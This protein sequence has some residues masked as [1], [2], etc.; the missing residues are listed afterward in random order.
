MMLLLK[1]TNEQL[2]SIWLILFNWAIWNKSLSI[3]EINLTKFMIKLT[4]V[5]VDEQHGI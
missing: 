5:I 4:N 3:Y 2:K 1:K